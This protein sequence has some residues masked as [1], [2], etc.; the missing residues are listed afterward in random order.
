MSMQSDLLEKETWNCYLDE[1]VP[2]SVIATLVLST[3]F[4][5][6]PI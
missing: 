3:D 2:N 5:T 6:L 1:L 4:D